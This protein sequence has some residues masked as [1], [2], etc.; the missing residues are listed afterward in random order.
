[1][2][3]DQHPVGIPKKYAR[4]IS[5]KYLRMLAKLRVSSKRSVRYEYAVRSWAGDAAVLEQLLDAMKKSEKI[6]YSGIKA[7]LVPSAITRSV[8][9]NVDARDAWLRLAASAINRAEQLDE[10]R[11]SQMADLVN[12]RKKRSST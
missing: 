3:L 1:M 6:K 12:H 9:E 7:Y 2:A 10:T 5:G 8:R 11:A 4:P